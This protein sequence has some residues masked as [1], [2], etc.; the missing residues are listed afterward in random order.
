MDV[1]QCG[2]S[3]KERQSSTELR[4]STAEKTPMCRGNQE[5]DETMQT[6]VALPCGKKGRC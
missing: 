2:V 1:T 5:Y 4:S 3:L 6:E